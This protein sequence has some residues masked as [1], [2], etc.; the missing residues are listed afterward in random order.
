MV[1]EGSCAR[2]AVHLYDSSKREGFVTERFLD[3]VCDRYGLASAVHGNLEVTAQTFAE[4]LRCIAERY[5]GSTLSED[6]LIDFVKSLHTNELLLALSCAKGTEAG[7]Q[8][9]VTLYRKYLSDLC[10]HLLGRSRDLEELGESL[11]IDLFLLDRSGQSRIASYDGRSSLTT[12]LRVVVSNRVI[13]ERHRRSAATGNLEVIPE[14]ADPRAHAEV[15]D[16]VARH[17]YKSIVLSAFRCALSILSERETLLVLMRYDQGLQL[18]EI[19]RMFSVHQSTITRQLGRIIDRLRADVKSV[20]A[21][22]YGLDLEQI[23][24]CLTV[25]CDTFERSESILGLLK[26]R[27]PGDGPMIAH[28]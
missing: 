21:S 9:F 27:S 1:S 3:L 20:L 8:R 28:Q 14:P 12:W 11:W 18:G 16:L 2:Q 22:Q 6:L 19:A 4:H 10:R 24:E 13:N 5:L 15:E 23:N 17:R 26:E 25:A 7:W